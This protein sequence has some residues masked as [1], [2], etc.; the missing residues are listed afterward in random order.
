MFICLARKSI[1]APPG[2]CRIFRF[3]YKYRCMTMNYYEGLKTVFFA[4]HL[5]KC[6]E[7]QESNTLDAVTRIFLLETLLF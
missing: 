1:P 2:G 3:S 6:E 7:Y 5:D 4:T